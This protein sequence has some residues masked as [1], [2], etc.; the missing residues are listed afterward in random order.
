M[1]NIL[2]VDFSSYKEAIASLLRENGYAVDLC[3][4]AYDAMAKMKVA[5]YDLIVSEVELP[6]D[7]AFD[8]YY[9]VNKNYPYIPM[10]M[11]TDRDID[12]FFS[13][14][15]E[16]GIGNVLCKPLKKNEF[17]NLA[18]KLMTKENI[19]GLEN[20]L[21]GLIEQNK[22][23]VTASMQ[24]QKAIRAIIESIEAWGFTLK[25]KVPLNLVLNEMAINAVY[26]SHGLTRE[27]EAR[28]QVR[29]KEGEHVDIFF[30]R[31]G[32]KYGI[33]IVDYN[34]ILTKMRILESINR[35]VEQ[36]MLLE[37]AFETGDD[38]SDLISETGRGFDLVRK[39]SGE[40]Y[41]IIKEGERTEVIL[42]FDGSGKG[43]EESRSSLKIIEAGS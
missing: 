7:N 35:V 18:E 29:L 1:R 22:I 3:G 34:G 20:Y 15:F 6:G 23:I 26:H 36:S 21:P 16:Q 12:T 9:Y 42:I 11:T 28:I 24:I 4:S 27:K 17:L 32:S 33:A 5:D 8:L 43:F 39:L 13:R 19:F 30:G 37:K 10:I 38:V 40:Y 14:I 41:F 2:V 25:N 31:S